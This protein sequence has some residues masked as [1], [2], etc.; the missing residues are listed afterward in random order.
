MDIEASGFGRGSY[1]IEIG[2][3][4]SDGRALCMLVKPADT[5]RHWDVQAQS[6]HGLTR[7]TLLHHG[8]AALDVARTLNAE[9]RGQTVYCDG[10]AH[11]YAWLAV[12]YEEAGCPP[13]F[14]LSSVLELLGEDLLPGLDGARQTAL[15]TLG[16]TR[17]R[18]SNDARALQQ[19]LVR[20]RGGALTA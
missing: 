4:L 10:W 13:S 1:P 6:T 7:D 2:V 19:A 17:H 15:A 20:L 18:A 8:R 14:R 9:L 16:L 3:A 12:L 11:D 5:W